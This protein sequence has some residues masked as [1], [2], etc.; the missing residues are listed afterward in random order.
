[1]VYQARVLIVEDA[2]ALAE[3]YRNY[4][5]KDSCIVELAIT[6]E[7]ALTLLDSFNPD[8]VL[9]DVN[10]PDMTGLEV[11]R[12]IKARGL[13]PEFVIMTAN[14]SVQLAVQSMREG[15]FEFLMKPLNGERLRTTVR[16]AL[17]QTPQSAT[18]QRHSPQKGTPERNNFAGFIG[19]SPAMSAIYRMLENAAPSNATVFLTGES[20]TGKELCA[21]ALHQLSR[22][23]AGPFVALNCAAIPRDIL[24]SELFGHVKGAY[25]GAHTDRKGAVMRADGGTLFLD[26]ICEMDPGLQ[27][28]LLRFLQ[29]RLVQRVGDD[30]PRPADIRIVCATNRD[31]LAEVSAGRFREDLFYRLHVVPVELPP[32]RARGDDLLL[33]ANH[34]LQLFAIEDAKTFAGFTEAAAQALLAHNW[35]GNVRQ[36]QNVVRNIVVMQPGPMIEFEALPQTIRQSPHLAAADALS[37][38]LSQLAAE[39]QNPTAPIHFSHRTRLAKSG[40]SP[41]EPLDAVIRRTIEEAISHFDGSV[42]RAAAALEVAPSTVYRRMQIWQDTDGTSQN[43]VSMQ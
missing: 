22:R 18:T 7:A 13:S 35:P 9:L 16:N 30:T 40:S 34:F 33:I 29:T 31:P 26:E 14:G 32:L 24:E 37:R 27:A 4:L 41:I 8:L 17:S 23:S 6:G 38:G 10:L 42:P 1:M 43:Y 28:K 19:N 39:A 11:L 5:I 15:A 12:R 25:T 3:T 20:G 2:I 21:E 36:L